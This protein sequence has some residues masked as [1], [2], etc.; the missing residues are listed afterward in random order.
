MLLL[1]R[2]TGQPVRA[3]DGSLVGDLRDLSVRVDGDHPAAYRLAVGT[4][5][6]TTHLIPWSAVASFEHSLVLV[7]DVGDLGRFAVAAGPLPLEP[8]ELLLRRDVLDTQVVDVVGHHLA[9]VSDV[10][11]TRVPDRRLEVAAVDVGVGAVLR[12]LGLARLGERIPER[13]LDWRDLHLTS[14]RGHRVQLATPAAA[15]HRLD[16]RALAELLTRLDVESATD[17]MLA[18]GTERTAGAVARAHP[19]VAG[20]LLRALEPGVAGEV[21]E[22]L[23]EESARRYR[24]ALSARSPLTRRRFRR[25]LGWRVQR[26]PRHGTPTSGQPGV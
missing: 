6:R 20:R 21:L 2:E 11:L 16:A 13:A 12:R 17:V 10:L 14:D 22:T 7:R 25:H 4:R 18:V 26:P 9:R 1:T 24:D 8:G 19:D 5:R 23:P 15:V 3:S